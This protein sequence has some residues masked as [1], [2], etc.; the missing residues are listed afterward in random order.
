MQ[1][2]TKGKLCGRRECSVCFPR[3]F[4]SC[5]EVNYLVDK[6]LNTLLIAKSSKEPL[7]FKCTKCEHMFGARPCNFFRRGKAF[8]GGSSRFCPYCRSRSLCQSQECDICFEKSFASHEMSEFWDFEKNHQNPRRVFV[9]SQ[10]KFWFKCGTCKHSFEMKLVSIKRE[11]FCPFCERRKVRNVEDREPCGGFLP[12][13]REETR[14]GET[15]A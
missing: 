4:A 12:K 11:R 5:D 8:K 15:Q 6:Q 10:H 2:S 14:P 7:F 1:C 3:S 13:L 9:S